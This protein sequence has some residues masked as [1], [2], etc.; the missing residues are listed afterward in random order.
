MRV[1]V[2]LAVRMLC[3]ASLL[4]A[5]VAPVATLAAKPGSGT[6]KDYSQL[7]LEELLNRDISVA[8][9]KTRV[10]VAKAPVSVTALTPEDI[11]RSGA[12]NIGDLLRTIPGIDV[13]ESFP[14][15]ISVSAR[16]TSE[17]FS[18]NMLVLIDGRRLETQLA[19]VPFLEEAP[20]RLEDI[21][22][23]E[24]VKGPVGA[25]YG[26]NALAGVISITTYGAEDVPGTLVSVGGGDRDTYAGS[27]RHAGRLGA[28]PWAYKVVGGYNYSSTWG[29]LDDADT[30]P[31]VALRKADVLGLLERKV[32]PDG[33][34]EMEA[35]YSKGDLASLTIVT[36]Q[37]QYYEYPHLRLGYSRPR[38][39]TLLTYN[40]QALE[41]RERV[42][43][44]QPLVDRWSHAVNLSIDRTLSPITSSTLTAGGNLR[45]QRSTFTSLGVPR[46]QVVGSVFVQNEQVVVKD[47]LLLFGAVGLSHHPE[48]DLQ[49]DGNA[50]V[51]VTPVDGH[52]LRASFGRG[53]RDPSFL[54]NF[55]D[56]RRRI[57]NQDGYQSSNKDLAPESMQ[58]WELGYRGRVKLGASRVQVFADAFQEKIRGLIGIVTNPVPAGSLEQF[59]TVTIVQQFQNVD[60][61][62][63]R[64]FE[65]GAELETTP[66]RLSA[67]YSFQDFENVATGDTILRDAPRHKLSAG[68]RTQKGAVELDLWVHSVSKTIED[69]GYVLVNPRLGVKSGPW[70]L[71]LQAF[72]ALNDRHLETANGRGIKGESIGRQVTLGVRYTTR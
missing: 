20:V 44:I 11:R 13:L 8:A 39:H 9:T 14:S 60:D 54:E 26:T 50:A 17:A 34:I 29:S 52:T 36:N 21:K 31:P 69:K 16:G 33:R 43:P 72:N 38:L 30:T 71:S 25:L 48:I 2:L 47:R 49:V 3:C 6:S 62:D 35:G 46:E 65:T 42:P 58:A 56:F 22:R 53:H 55:I 4:N 67:Q 19:G 64:G 57:A 10:E 23:I 40:P 63:G 70:M 24:V 59:P 7:N 37:T 1:A 32:G 41:L 5:Q 28:S 61:R 15:Y 68:L 45:Y 12:T 66:V 27:I 51:I 18:N